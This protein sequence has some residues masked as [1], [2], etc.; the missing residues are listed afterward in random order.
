MTGTVPAEE[1]KMS[2]RLVARAEVF[3]VEITGDDVVLDIGSGPGGDCMLAGSVGADVIA[4]NINGGELD[5]LSEQMRSVPARS[6]RAVLCDCNAG[7]MPLS[8]GSATVI[9]AK[10]IMEHLDA[11]DRFLADLARL[12]R[13]GARYLITVP[14][15]TSESLLREVAPPHY[16]QKPL[17]QHVFNREQIDVMLGVA[18]L[19]LERRS[20]TGSYWSIFWALREL[21][22]SQYFPGNPLHPV[23]PPAIAAWDLIWNE[24]QNSPRSAGVIHRLDELLPKSQIIV[25]R[26]PAGAASAAA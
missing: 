5:R 7:P 23:P 9:I 1:T 20:L 14:D 18:G 12:G 6:F 22:G 3:G 17:H 16:W 2:E 4:V 21:V 10:E 26:K 24:I 8:D 11:P 15:P 25:A 13:P 19:E